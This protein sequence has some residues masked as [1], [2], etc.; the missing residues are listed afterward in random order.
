MPI[1]A[2]LI[3]FVAGCGGSSDTPPEPDTLPPLGADMLVFDSSRSG[4]HEIFVMRNDGSGARQLTQDASYE[5]W[6]PRLS[7]DRRKL[8]FYRAP[9]GLPERYDLASLWTIQVDGTALTQL[10]AAGADGWPLQ[11]HGEWS[12]NGAAIAMFGGSSATS[13]QIYVTDAMGRSPRQITQRPGI[14]TD[15]SWS[16]DGRTLLFNGCPATPC[17]EAD[18]EIYAIPAAGGS[19]T[20]LTFDGVADYD[21]YFSPDGKTIAWLVKSDPAAYNG[22]GAWSIRVASADGSNA[23]WLINDGQINSKP[24]W[25]LDGANIYFHRMEPAREVRWGVFRIGVDGSALTPLTANA[26][27]NNEF[28]SN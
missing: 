12:P 26:A 28:P 15:V 20:R 3:A 8:L 1:I 10:R 21:P 18:Y 5:N 22:L 16:P 14:N 27:G 23:R 25:S 2:M 4:N 24:A 11:G 13:P 6:W 9:R 7:P 19:E 17:A